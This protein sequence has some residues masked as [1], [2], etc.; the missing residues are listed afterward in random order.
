M[1]IFLHLILTIFPALLFSLPENTFIDWKADY[2]LMWDDFKAPPDKNSP[3]AAETSTAIK[4]DF[5][6]DGSNLKYHI[7]CQFD[8]NKSWGRVKIDYILSHEQ[9]HFDIAEIFARK[10]NKSLKEYTVG[11]VGNLNK[12]VNK[13]YDN[14]M[15]QL[16]N[17]QVAYDTETNFSINKARQE[18]W[19]KKISSELKD[20]EAY[21][22][23][24]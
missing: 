20:L 22:N 18:E 16:H 8:K 13:I 14:T 7:T 9:G 15:H 2:K 23:Y 19:L 21:A 12:E 4:F 11:N 1:K 5:S 17:M 24:R 6:Y 10:L 3:N